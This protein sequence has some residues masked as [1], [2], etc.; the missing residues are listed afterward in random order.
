MA[1]KIF[2]EETTDYDQFKIINGN[3]SVNEIHLERLK[4]SFADNYLLSPIIVNEK[5]E[6][7]DGQHRFQAA[8]ELELPVYYLA[9]TGF[10]LKEIQIYNT[11]STNWK[12]IDFLHMFC[13]LGKEPYI[14]F[15]EFME[16]FPYFG[17]LACE[18]MLRNRSGNMTEQVGGR[19]VQKDY[20]EDGHLI[21]EDWDQGIDIAE[22]LIQIKP[23]YKGFARATFVSCMISL[24]KHENFHFDK[25]MEKLELQP[26]SLVHCN[27]VADYKLLIEDIYNFRAR[28]PV[29]LRY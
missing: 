12:K 24:L 26:N 17:L 2:V 18:R 20:F 4:K 1:Q 9:V 22:K 14:K 6:I 11:N 28:N 21:I 7:I 13:D 10:G 29:N 3:R 5:F 25:F 8:K 19:K 27:K 15:K 16:R 23:Y